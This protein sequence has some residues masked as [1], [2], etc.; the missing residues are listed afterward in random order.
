MEVI[1]RLQHF[2]RVDANCV[3]YPQLCHLSRFQRGGSLGSVL[4]QNLNARIGLCGLTHGF[5]GFVQY[6]LL[7]FL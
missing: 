4:Q 1:K 2:K 5:S 3:I 7:L 6:N